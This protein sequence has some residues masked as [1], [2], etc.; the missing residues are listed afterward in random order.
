MGFLFLGGLFRS[1]DPLQTS[2]IKAPAQIDPSQGLVW[3][4][5]Q[6]TVSDTISPG[7]AGRVR[8]KGSWWP[9]KCTQHLTMYPGD[10]VQ[11]IGVKNITLIVEPI[12]RE[13]LEPRGLAQA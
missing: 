6:A 1:T 11:V 7:K 8:F 2:A 9:A 3:T 10:V 13:V 12:V 5:G 4:Q